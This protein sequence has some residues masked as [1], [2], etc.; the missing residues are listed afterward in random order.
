MRTYQAYKFT[1]E[2]LENLKKGKCWCGKDSVVYLIHCLFNS[3][4]NFCLNF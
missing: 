2:E 1:D 3:F 4:F